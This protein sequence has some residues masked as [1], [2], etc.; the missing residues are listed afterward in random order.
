MS[1]DDKQPADDAKKEPDKEP[2][3]E[4]PAQAEE[5]EAGADAEAGLNRAE[6][7]RRKHR[8]KG[9]LRQLHDHGRSAKKDTKGHTGRVFRRKSF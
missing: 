5:G 3:E 8:R 1:E 9:E 6:R 7:R 4:P 2:K